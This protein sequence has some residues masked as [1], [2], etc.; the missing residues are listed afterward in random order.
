[1]SPL[2]GSGRK[3]PYSG[4]FRVVMITGGRVF[5]NPVEPLCPVAV[6]EVFPKLNTIHKPGAVMFGTMEGAVTGSTG[7]LNH[8]NH[9]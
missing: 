1:M 8:F 7:H 4:Y 2:E 6:V 3:V 9:L 5:I